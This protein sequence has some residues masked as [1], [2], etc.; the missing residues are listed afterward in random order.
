MIKTFDTNI[1]QHK[2][3]LCQDVLME[4]G[5]LRFPG[6]KEIKMV[7]TWKKE[8]YFVKMLRHP[9]DPSKI[10]CLDVH[11]KCDKCGTDQVFI[12]AT[13]LDDKRKINIQ[14]NKIGSSQGKLYT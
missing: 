8:N 1:I 5:Y 10:I 4:S 12:V 2:C 11:C 3:K 9:L 6:V 13:T 14:Y 7:G